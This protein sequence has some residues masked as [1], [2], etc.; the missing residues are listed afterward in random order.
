MVMNEDYAIKMENLS[1][2]YFSFERGNSISLGKYREI[3][4]LKDINLKIL[5]GE[6][7][8]ILG[9]NGAGKTTLLQAISGSLDR[10]MEKFRLMVK[11]SRSEDPTQ[12]SSR[13][14]PQ[15]RT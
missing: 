9:K 6:S 11:F 2:S 1:I 12:D 10:N 5:P 8:A 14:S 13:T 15:D 3:E 7:V 4:A